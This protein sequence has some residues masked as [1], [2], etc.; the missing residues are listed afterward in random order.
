[1]AYYYSKNGEQFGPMP[2]ESLLKAIDE[3][4]LV[5]NDD[6]SMKEW[7]PAS[8]I[9]KINSTKQISKNLD[10]LERQIIS[11]YQMPS[12]TGWGSNAP[13]FEL[14]KRVSEEK[15]LTG[16]DAQS[17]VNKVLSENGIVQKKG[18]F[19]ATAC[20]G[21][22][23]APEVIIFRRYRDEVLLQSKSGRMFVTI[24][25][26][27]SPSLARAINSS[28]EAKRIIRNYILEPILKKIAITYFY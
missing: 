20:Y 5:W 21:D 17:Y 23:D 2:I 16:K 28:D 27:T 26:F 10:D 19:I 12:V 3:N 13:L 22:Y 18:C 15:G 1:M 9:F 14:Y 4:T 24:Y 7:Q 8:S 6:G 25:Y 11:V